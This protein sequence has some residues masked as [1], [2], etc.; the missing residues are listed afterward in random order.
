MAARKEIFP[1]NL[2]TLK[3]KL[4]LLAKQVYISMESTLWQITLAFHRSTFYLLWN[5]LKW[6]NI[7]RLH[8]MSYYHAVFSWSMGIDYNKMHDVNELDRSYVICFFSMTGP[9]CFNM[10]AV[11]HPSVCA[12]MFFKLLIMAIFSYID[13]KKHCKTL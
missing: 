10:Y 8:P 11:V 12:Y 2:E 9:L 1:Y 6:L 13:R 5:Q 7:R 3:K 4:H